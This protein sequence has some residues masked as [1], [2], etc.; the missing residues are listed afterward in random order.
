MEGKIF[1]FKIFLLALMM[2]FMRINIVFAEESR[3]VL[4]IANSPDQ[5]Y[6]LAIKGFKDQLSAQANIHFT[7]LILARLNDKARPIAEIIEKNKTNLIYSLGEESTE[8]AMKNSLNIPIIAT[9]IL[10]NKLFAQAANIT[11]VSLNYPLVTQFQWLKKMFPGYQRVA[12]LFNPQENAG[13]AQDVQ[14][15]AQMEG[16][17]LLTIPVETPKQMPYALEQLEKN[18]DILLSIPDEIAMSPK[19]AREV[20]LASFRNK[21]PLV[22]LSDNWVKSGALY[23]LSWDYYDLGEQCAM[24]SKNLF[25]GIPLKK[26]PP[27]SPRKVTYSINAKIAEHM[28]IEISETLLKNAKI[29]FN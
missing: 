24:Q 28:K 15:S 25:R 18:V 1:Y 14:K 22:G 7:E 6:Q 5:P 3:H 21:V 8:L 26:V 4:I 2:F 11:G 29:I 20:L 23:S 10:T 9:L 27:E 19:T 13:V 17:E 12:L 16:L